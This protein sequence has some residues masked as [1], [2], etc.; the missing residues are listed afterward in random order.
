M[1]KKVIFQKGWH[2]SEAL[3]H[4]SMQNLWLVTLQTLTSQL[5]RDFIHGTR[6]G[7][8]YVCAAGL[9]GSL[10]L[11]ILVCL[12][13]QLMARPAGQDKKGVQLKFKRF[14][15]PCCLSQLSDTSLA[16]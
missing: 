15:S 3:V 14:T 9:K 1:C 6:N 8:C 4:S 7:I 10:Y 2:D 13:L 16:S 11:Q 5:Q 12:L